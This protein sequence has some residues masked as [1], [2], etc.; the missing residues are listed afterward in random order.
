MG[1]IFR[2]KAEVGGNARMPAGCGMMGM[3]NIPAGSYYQAGCRLAAEWRVKIRA[4][5]GKIS[6][7]PIGG[8]AARQ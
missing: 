7:Y 5:D 1:R 8:A 3:S 2:R 6:N 4:P